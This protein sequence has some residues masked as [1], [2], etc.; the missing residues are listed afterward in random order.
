MNKKLIV[1]FLLVLGI[2]GMAGFRLYA[3]RLPSQDAAS[4]MQSLG[5]LEGSF[6]SLRTSLDKSTKELSQKLD[7]VLA[8]QQTILKELEVVKV[9]ASRK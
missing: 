3:Q 9:R 2:V 4:A 8:N 5:G 1:G 6:S 7:Q